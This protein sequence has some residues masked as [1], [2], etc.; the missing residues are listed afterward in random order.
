M[1]QLRLAIHTPAGVF[2]HYRSTDISDLESFVVAGDGNCLEASFQAKASELGVGA[3]DIVTLELGQLIA[4]GT[5]DENGHMIYTV[6]W[7]TRFRGMAVTPGAARSRE[8]SSFKLAGLKKRFYELPCLGYSFEGGDVAA[9]AQAILAYTDPET[10]DGNVP[11]GVSVQPLPVLLG[12][13]SGELRPNLNSVGDVL[14]GLAGLCPG[15]EVLPGSSYTYDGVTYEPGDEVPPVTWGVKADG[16]FFFHRDAG[17]LSLGETDP[18]TVLEWVEVDAEKLVTVTR[19]FYGMTTEEG[20]IELL[21]TGIELPKTYTK[22]HPQASVLGRAEEVVPIQGEGA[23]I[24]ILPVPWSLVQGDRISGVF[25]DLL[26]PD[27]EE[28]VVVRS[29]L[30]F[31][32]EEGEIALVNFQCSIPPGMEIDGFVV[33]RDNSVPTTWGFTETGTVF[34]PPGL[35][36]ALS[37]D[38]IQINGK[39]YVNAPANPAGGPG[40]DFNIIFLTETSGQDIELNQ[41]YMFRLN[42]ELLDDMAQS[43]F[44]IPASNPATV[45]RHGFSGGVLAP[46]PYVDLA[47][48]SGEIVSTKVDAIAYRATRQGGFQAEVRL[49][50]RIPSEYT[51]IRDLIQDRT[52]AAIRK[53]S[54]AYQNDH[55]VSQYRRPARVAQA[56][57]D[58]LEPV[59]R[60]IK[61]NERGDTY[62]A[63]AVFAPGPPTEGETGDN[64]VA[65]MFGDEWMLTLWNDWV[66]ELYHW[67]GSSWERRNPLNHPLFGEG[68]TVETGARHITMCWDQS[69]RLI[70]AYELDGLIKVTRWDATEQAY[71]QNVSFAGRDPL[72][73]MDATCMFRISGSDVALFYLSLDRS[74]LHNR[75]QQEN[76]GTENTSK[77]LGGVHYLD[78]LVPGAYDVYLFLGDSTG[79]AT[80]EPLR[81]ALYPVYARDSFTAS[82]EGREGLYELVAIRHEALEQF[83]VSAEALDGEYVSAVV[84]HAQAEQPLLVSADAR[85][86]SYEQVVLRHEAAEE[87]VVDAE[88]LEGNYEQSAI[89]HQGTDDFV[90]SA[91]ALDGSYEPA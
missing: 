16:S 5:F 47:L 19:F 85:D 67:N 8:L 89:R 23:A 43:Y 51:A 28:G 38:A 76:Y 48:T 79:A 11:A 29:V 68:V 90:V 3:R 62:F 50:Q 80:A 4:T 78:Q 39:V 61:V 36:G 56:N 44:H 15:F 32:N 82:G 41:L 31:G 35:L 60:L 64:D 75:V 6:G 12:L 65:V 13:E 91:E 46:K 7:N 53:Q 30:L 26:D 14:D 33:D 72:L 58:E 73:F 83:A 10:G 21:R 77:A 24:E 20:M 1:D 27:A 2:K 18:G 40:L 45:T 63:E 42:R 9:V 86:G 34:N 17:R 52:D 59:G 25:R 84:S 87:L 55:Y 69:A 22:P 57:I 74:T 66:L 37:K 54:I 70:V 49:E 88:L 71:V 81:A